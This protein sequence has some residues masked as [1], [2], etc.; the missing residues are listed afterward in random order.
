V[1]RSI[2]LFILLT[3]LLLAV[4]GLFGW[5]GRY[6]LILVAIVALAITIGERV[7]AQRRSRTG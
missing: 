2:V 3:F 6:E 1:I 4:V 5:I 7:A